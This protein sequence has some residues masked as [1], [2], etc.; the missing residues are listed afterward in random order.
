[1]LKRPLYIDDLPGCR[2]SLDQPALRVGADGK[3][4][5]L[6]PLARISRIHCRDSVLWSMPALLACADTGITV[7][8]STP[9]GRLRAK[10]QPS[11]DKRRIS[12][13]GLMAILTRR[14]GQTVFENWFAAME[15]MAARSFARRFG[16]IA[17]RTVDVAP[18]RRQILLDLGQ[19]GRHRSRLLRS[20]IHAEVAGWLQAAGI[21]P[22]DELFAVAGIDLAEAFSQLLLW[23]F[24]GALLTAADGGGD[25]RPLPAM[26]ALFQARSERCQ[27]LFRSALSK[28][29]PLLRAVE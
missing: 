14:E 29:Y 19:P 24:N 18:L 6:F 4:D 17:W 11:A 21:G 8:F 12:D 7:L 10:W 27:A 9:D 15:K 1:M 22:D 13:P 26:A 25:K 3:A 28:L 23:D 20:I 16:L 5:Q 2:V